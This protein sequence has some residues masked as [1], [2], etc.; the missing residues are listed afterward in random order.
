MEKEYEGNGGKRSFVFDESSKRRVENFEENGNKKP[1]LLTFWA[2]K[3]TKKKNTLTLSLTGSFSLIAEKEENGQR[4]STNTKESQDYS[5]NGANE[6]QLTS[7]P[8][9]KCFGVLKGLLI[10]IHPKLI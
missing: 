2:E 7:E 8:K 4:E 10:Q 1:L 9:A 3:E 6:P 5:R